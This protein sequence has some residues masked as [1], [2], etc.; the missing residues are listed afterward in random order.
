[1]FPATD[2]RWLL[3]H[4]YTP[5]AIDLIDARAGVYTA[6]IYMQIDAA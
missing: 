4:A 6:T 2:A 1:M 3:F 5:L